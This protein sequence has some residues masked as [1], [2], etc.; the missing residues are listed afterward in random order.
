MIGSKVGQS[1]IFRWLLSIEE[2]DRSSK[3]EYAN[4]AHQMVHFKAL[5]TTAWVLGTPKKHANKVIVNQG[6]HHNTD[7]SGRM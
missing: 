3:V 1:I 4:Y 6:S 5:D 7:G 2:K